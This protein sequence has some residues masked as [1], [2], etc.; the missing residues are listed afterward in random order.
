[1]L[2]CL[3]ASLKQFGTR[4][5]T[6]FAN[7]R[8][9]QFVLLLLFPLRGEFAASRILSLWLNQYETSFVVCRGVKTSQRRSSIVNLLIT[10]RNSAKF[11]DFRGERSAQVIFRD[12]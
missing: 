10:H 2:L 11:I 9:F 8:D 12:R 6:D 3:R 4:Y 5:A 7:G 1:M